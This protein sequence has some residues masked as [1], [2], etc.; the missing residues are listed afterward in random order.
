MN[1]VLI[2]F[3][4]A[5]FASNGDSVALDNISGFASKEYCQQAGE[6]VVRKFKT[7]G[8][9]SGKFICVRTN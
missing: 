9:K 2:I 7:T 6:E 5:G 4:Y 1:Y 8:F 3:M